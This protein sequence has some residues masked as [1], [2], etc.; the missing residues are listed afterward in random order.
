[1][2]REEALLDVEAGQ[3]EDTIAWGDAEQPT[4]IR[5]L[6]TPRDDPT[7]RLPGASDDPDTVPRPIDVEEEEDDEDAPTHHAEALAIEQPL[8]RSSPEDTLAHA[9][10]D[11]TPAPE[12][13]AAA[14]AT[15]P[16][17]VA[18]WVALVMM[19]L[20]AAF[21]GGVAF[22][23]SVTPQT[24]ALNFTLPPDV[25]LT[26]DGEEITTGGNAPLQISLPPGAA[27]DVTIAFPEPAPPPEPPP[28]AEP[29]APGDL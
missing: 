8:L 15:D 13:P 21:G 25:L 3:D 19:L 5:Q 16:A 17:R 9:P 10:E 18:M 11:T 24:P 28:E 7:V 27:S 4:A 1:M 12:A 6:S 29:D 26:I 23:R 2:H 14:P 22:Q 20:C